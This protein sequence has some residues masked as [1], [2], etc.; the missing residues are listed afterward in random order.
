MDLKER[1]SVDPWTHWYYLAKLNAIRQHVVGLRHEMQS[2]LD[3]GAGSG[4]FSLALT[5]ECRDAVVTCVDP[6]YRDDELGEHDR[7]L[8]VRVADPQTV[9]RADT[10]LFIDVLE[11][12]DDDRSLLRSYVD[13][14]APG[15][16]IVVSVP[17]FMS[18][19]SPHDD[20]LEHRRRYRLTDIERV[21]RESGL[22]VVEARYLFGAI[23]PAVW[24][25]RRLRRGRAAASDMRP[26]LRPL[27]W[28]LATILSFEHRHLRNRLGGLSAFVVARKRGDDA[29]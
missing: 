6:N 11:H 14:A 26:T 24:A 29:D 20:F 16:V 19:W 22:E 2:V 15:C 18:L 9:S 7:A 10:M 25:V 12:V 4:F 17:A 28:F 5:R 21:V 3:V 13:L 1:S 27:N 23:L 8:Y